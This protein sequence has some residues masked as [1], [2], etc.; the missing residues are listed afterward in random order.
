MSQHL[1]HYSQK[2]CIGCAS[3]EGGAKQQG[4]IWSMVGLATLTGGI[5]LFVPLFFK[6][7]Q[8][9]GHSSWMNRHGAPVSGATA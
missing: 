4:R 5:F 3:C 9:C 6:R 1:N 7:C 2:G 8:Y